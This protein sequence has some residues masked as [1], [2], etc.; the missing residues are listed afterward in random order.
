MQRIAEASGTFGTIRFELLNNGLDDTFGMGN[1]KGA[2][3]GHWN[4]ITPSVLAAVQDPL[5]NP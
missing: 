3:E 1:M 4:L 2:S 5:L